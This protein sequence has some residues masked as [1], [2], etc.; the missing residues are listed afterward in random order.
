MPKKLH[1]SLAV[2]LPDDPFTASDVYKAIQPAW[3]ALLDALKASGAAYDLH[4]KEMEAKPTRGRPRK[5]RI[6]TVPAEAA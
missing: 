5:P 6:A 2:S 3:A 4:F 1:V